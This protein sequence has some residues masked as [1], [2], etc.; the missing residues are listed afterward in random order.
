MKLKNIGFLA[1]IFFTSIFC[2]GS[3]LVQGNQVRLRKQI[4]SVKKNEL[5]HEEL[6]AVETELNM[7]SNVYSQETLLEHAIWK[8]E[9]KKCCCFRVQEKAICE[10][11]CKCVVYQAVLCAIYCLNDKYLELSENKL[12]MAKNCF[13]GLNAFNCINCLRET[14]SHCLEICKRN[15]YLRKEKEQKVPKIQNME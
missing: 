1:I 9:S 6:V 15:N 14:E 3:D 11:C 13:L 2:Y 4:Q 10:T 12:I 5:N 8:K 7:P